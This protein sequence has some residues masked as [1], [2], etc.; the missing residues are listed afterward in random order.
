MTIR[1]ATPSETTDWNNHILQNAD[2]GNIFQSQEFA[3]QKQQSGWTPRYIVT[4]DTAM[5]VLQKHIIGLGNH[6]YIPKGPG[7]IDVVQL[8]TLLPELRQ[9]ARQN[10]VFSVKIEPEI[11][12]SEDARIELNNLELIRTTPIQPN[13]ATVNVNLNESLDEI[14]AHLNQKGRH[15]I[16]R[17]RRDGVTIAAVDSSDENCQIMYRLLADTAAGSFRIRSYDYYRT[18]WQRYADVSKGQLFF[19]YVDGQIVAGAYAMIFGTKSTYKDGASIRDRTT[20]GASHLLQWSVIE[21]AKSRGALTHDLCGT[22]SAANIKDQT[23]PYYGLGRF[24]TSFNKQVTD[25]IGAYDLII[26]PASYRIWTNIGERIT[27]RLHTIRH[28]ENWW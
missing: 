4:G 27:L 19:A 25:Y 18:F 24:K 17:A 6:W 10:N 23:D 26:K 20:Y 16:N 22:P 28:H 1:F 14:M 13:A 12:D 2:G 9:F 3:Q 5:T 21:W 15:A 7:V 8:Q 11:I